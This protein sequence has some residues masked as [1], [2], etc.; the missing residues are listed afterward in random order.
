MMIYCMTYLYIET[1]AS[2]VYVQC[3]VFCGMYICTVVFSVLHY[4]SCSS[5]ATTATSNATSND[6]SY[7]VHTHCYDMCIDTSEMQH[8]YVHIQ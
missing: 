2:R 3:E 8:M 5:T 4:I 6:S 7:E 1:L